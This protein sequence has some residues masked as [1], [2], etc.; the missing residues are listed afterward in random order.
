[1]LDD[2]PADDDFLSTIVRPP[3][4]TSRMYA[5][6]T[7]PT[8]WAFRSMSWVDLVDTIPL[9]RLAPSCFIWTAEPNPK[10]TLC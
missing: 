8:P 2:V 10:R 4:S 6:D 7:E 9:T 3:N 5:A 1:M